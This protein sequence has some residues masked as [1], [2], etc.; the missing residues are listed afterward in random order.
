MTLYFFLNICGFIQETHEKLD[1][2][3]ITVNVI[4]GEF[5]IESHYIAIP[6]TRFSFYMYSTEQMRKIR[7]NASLFVWL[8]HSFTKPPGYIDGIK[9]FVTKKRRVYAKF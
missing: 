1:A 6:Q 2:V 3:L 5:C 8:Q 4:F 7:N 9:Y